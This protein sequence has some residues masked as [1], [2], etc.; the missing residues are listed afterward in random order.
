MTQGEG[1]TEDVPDR[2]P[3]RS[4]RTLWLGGVPS[5]IIGVTSDF[6]ILGVPQHT[7]QKE[8]A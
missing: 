1:Y 5:R 4:L 3:P 2:P 7:Q 6:V 8:A